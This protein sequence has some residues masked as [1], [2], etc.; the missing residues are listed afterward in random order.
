MS[1]AAVFYHCAVFALLL[2]QSN[3]QETDYAEIQNEAG[4]SGP[5]SDSVGF[6]TKGMI[7][8]CT[9][10]G[11]VVV[12]GLSSTAL[13]FIAK[14]R[15]WEMRETMRRSARQVTQAIKTPLTPRF[16]KISDP[17]KRNQTKERKDPK[18]H[19]FSDLEKG[20]KSAKSNNCSVTVTTGETDQNSEGKARG[21]GSFFAFSRS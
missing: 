10:V 3:A 13:F 15:Q 7:A 1:S 18:G 5:E 12:I 19:E 17:H 16:P 21:W 2:A 11:V 6:S 20:L 14:K 8:L 9:I 4:A